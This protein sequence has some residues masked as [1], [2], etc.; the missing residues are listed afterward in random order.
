M[1]HD[2]DFQ[3][4]AER[5]MGDK[6]SPKVI[7]RGRPPDQIEMR[8]LIKIVEKECFDSVWIDEVRRQR[9]VK[10]YLSDKALSKMRSMVPSRPNSPQTTG[11]VATISNSDFALYIGQL[12]MI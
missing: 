4:L 7:F 12:T 6:R 8:K 11:M 1:I 5:F 3:I 10:F 9:A 2:G